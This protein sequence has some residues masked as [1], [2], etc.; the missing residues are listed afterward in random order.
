MQSSVCVCVYII[1][2]WCVYK[3]VPRIVCIAMSYV[4]ICTIRVSVGTSGEK[5]YL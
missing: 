1:N 2:S 4:L 3:Y 5:Q